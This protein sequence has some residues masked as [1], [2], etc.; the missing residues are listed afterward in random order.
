MPKNN[1]KAVGRT[2][3]FVLLTVAVLAFGEF[4]RQSM[5][6]VD[7]FSGFVKEVISWIV[8]AP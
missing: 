6:K 3:L 7:A 8:P 5:I 4:D 2:L 1:K